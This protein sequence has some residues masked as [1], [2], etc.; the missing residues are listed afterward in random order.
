[1]AGYHS[2]RK[3]FSFAHCHQNVHIVLDIVP[4][5]MVRASTSISSSP[6]AL[7]LGASF[8][9]LATVA[10]YSLSTLNSFR[11]GDQTSFA[12]VGICAMKVAG[13]SRLSSDSSPFFSLLAQTSEFPAI[14]CPL[15]LV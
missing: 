14:Y 10:S 2:L 5:S 15:G 7:I 12:G 11:C 6:V 4:G 1:M 3:C 9:A 8:M 13:S